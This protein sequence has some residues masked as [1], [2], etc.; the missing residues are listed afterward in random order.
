[1]ANCGNLKEGDIITCEDCGMALKVIKACK[2]GEGGD[3][4][5]HDLMQCCGK[6][7]EG[8]K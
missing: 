2:C 4:S 1:M 3:A 8:K 6:A 7:M 5:C